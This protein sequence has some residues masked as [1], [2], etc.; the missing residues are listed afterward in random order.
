MNWS[1]GLLRLW[2]VLAACWII[3]GLFL[4]IVITLKGQFNFLEH[5]FKMSGIDWA[6]FVF[7]IF[8]PPLLLLFLGFAVAWIARGFRNSGPPEG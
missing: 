8:I 1:R 2:G 7:L 6:Y 5:L 4:A 3:A